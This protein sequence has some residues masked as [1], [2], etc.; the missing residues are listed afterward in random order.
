MSYENISS[1]FLLAEI[2]KLL[3]DIVVKTS[4]VNQEI[5]MIDLEQVQ[6]SLSRQIICLE[7]DYLGKKRNYL[8]KR[9]NQLNAFVASIINDMKTKTV[10][11]DCG[12][13]NWYEIHDICANML[14]ILKHDNNLSEYKKYFCYVDCHI[15]KIKKYRII[16]CQYFLLKQLCLCPCLIKYIAELSMIGCILICV[17]D[18]INNCNFDGK[19]ILHEMHRVSKIMMKI[20]KDCACGEEIFAI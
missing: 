4:K 9:G 11:A 5:F 17:L 20:L 10:L 19:D 12:Q 3:D 8:L 15:A 1:Q 18:K 13:I 7:E 2:S 14:E 16:T 6:E